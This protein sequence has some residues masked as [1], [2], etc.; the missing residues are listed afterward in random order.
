[1]NCVPIHLR[2]NEPELELKKILETERLVLREFVLDDAEFIVRLVNS[3]GW[4]AF[5]GDRN[6]HSLLDGKEYLL[7]GPLKNYSLHGF[8]LYLVALK[9]GRTPIGMCGLLKRDYLDGVDLGFAILPAYEGKGYAT[10]AAQA[11]ITFARQSLG[12]LNVLA[13]VMP[14][15]VRSIRLLENIGMHFEKMIQQPP[16][17][18]TLMLFS[19]WS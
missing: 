18:E 9:A 3:P 6:I 13:I 1:M 12:L 16:D 17:N 14:G 5:I 8:G 15:N 11:T 19:T 10:E 4:L 2:N 7:N